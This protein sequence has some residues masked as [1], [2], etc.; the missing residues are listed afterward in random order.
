MWPSLNDGVQVSAWMAELA[1]QVE[2]TFTSGEASIVQTFPL[3]EQR[4]QEASAVAGCRIHT[5]S[6][7]RQ[8]TFRVLRSGDEIWTGNCASI[9]RHKLQVEQVGK[10][11]PEALM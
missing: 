1:P 3:K 6:L 10:A 4:G 11:S 8:S 5:G 9:R 7:S 2:E